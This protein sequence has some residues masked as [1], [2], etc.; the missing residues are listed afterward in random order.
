M[1]E[2][3]LELLSEG[4]RELTFAFEGINDAHVWRRPSQ[5]LLSIGEIA[6]HLIYW[7]SV[8]LAGGGG[9]RVQ[10]E[11]GISFRPF[12]EK[13]KVSSVLIDYRFSYQPENIKLSPTAEQ[14][15]MTA[16]EIG[17]EVQRVHTECVATIRSLN[18]DLDTVVTGWSEFWTYRNS[19]KYLIFHVGYHTGQIYTMRHMFGETT[20][21]N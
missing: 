3:Y 17:S 18:P 9:E 7:E 16:A 6:G 5:Q 11:N 19:L 12:I 15:A 14:L 20:P 4:Y 21:D 10:G 2:T 13:M 8:R 1:L